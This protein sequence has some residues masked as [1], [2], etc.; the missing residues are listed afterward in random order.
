TE[1]GLTPGDVSAVVVGTGPAP[2]TGLRAGLVTARVFALAR[3]VHV[4]GVCS[5]DALAAGAFAVGLDAGAEVLAVADARRRE[6]YAARYRAGVGGDVELVSGP[7]V[8]HPGE[9]T[10]L[11]S[12]AVVV[13]RGARAYPE[14]FPGALAPE[15]PD[16]AMLA[17]LAIGR[18]RRGLA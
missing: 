18:A 4:L 2:F 17:R 16:P 3:Q 13:G 9:V 1:A 11:A 6:V 12:G 14:A 5:L 10:G 7:L 15:V 8:D